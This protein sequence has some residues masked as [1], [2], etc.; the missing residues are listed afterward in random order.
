MD[1]TDW[2][3]EFRG[4]D[5][6]PPTATPQEKAARGRLLERILATMFDDAGLA[7]RLTY[8]PKGEEVD[9]SIWFHGRTIL[10]EA[11]WTADP[12]PASSLYQLKGKVDGK[13]VGTLGLFISIGGFSTDSAD[14]LLAGKELNLIL[15]DG[16][17]MRKIVANKFTVADALE[18]KLRAAG[19]AGT[20]F[21]PLT[22][23]LTP[24]STVAGQHLV[25]VEGRSDVRYLESVRRVHHASRKVTFVPA[26]GPRN[27]V[28]VTRTMLEVAESVLALTVLV[29][30]DVAGPQADRLTEDLKGLVSEFGLGPNDVDVIVVHP[31]LE[32][33]LGLTD[34]ETV[35]RNPRYLRNI[36]DTKLDTMVEKAD[37]MTR[38][39]RDPTLGKLLRAIGLDLG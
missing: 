10:I 24:Q 1:L 15:A 37:L 29:D 2:R 12:H 20:P 13:L 28:P 16:D 38:A 33:A 8:R 11:K 19:D 3:Q 17:D 9:G 32:G 23:T 31:D 34:S 6:L 25:I 39:A 21:L 18:L 36:A 35:L 14:A 5:D 26:S 7:P 27:M 4:A 22:D 30:G